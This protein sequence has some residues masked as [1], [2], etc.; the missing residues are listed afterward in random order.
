MYPFIDPSDFTF[1][2]QSNLMG[3]GGY[4]GSYPDD[5]SGDMGVTDPSQMNMAPP[6]P[7][8]NVPSIDYTPGIQAPRPPERN[9]MDVVNQLYTPSNDAMD[10]YNNLLNQYPHEQ[11]PSL[12][13]TIIASM[14]AG[15]NPKGAQEVMDDPYKKALAEWTQQVTPRYN[16]AQQETARNSN[17]RQ[18]AFGTAQNI[19]NQ[20]R[21]DKQAQT[22]QEKN[23]IA[24][25]RALAYQYKVEHP[26]WKITAPKG[27]FITAYNPA[28]PKETEVLKDEFGKPVATGTSTDADLADI[29]NRGV[30]KSSANASISPTPKASERASCASRST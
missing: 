22:A 4:G 10:A 28:N 11:R 17:E 8:P 21:Y 1:L 20:E 19:V 26:D 5:Y 12:G 9:I 2:R 16:A 24:R 30:K 18:L 6:T 15:S 3:G 27:G 25:I 7:P 29:N 23:D 14:M 13:R